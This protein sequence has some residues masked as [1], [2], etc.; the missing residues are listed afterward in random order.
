VLTSGV[1]FTAADFDL[2][3]RLGDDVGDG[4]AAANADALW[5]KTRR[6]I[7][8]LGAGLFGDGLYSAALWPDDDGG[9]R[10]PFLWARL[11]R[12]GSERFATHIG[13]F[14]S[15]GLC[16]LAI[17][18][19]KDP[20][21]AGESAESLAQVLDFYRAEALGLIDPPARPDLRVWTDTRNVIPAG[22]LGAVH[23]ADFMAANSDAGHPWPKV[24][25][26]LSAENVVDFGDDWLAEYHPRAVPLVPIYDAM[27]RSFTG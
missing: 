3:Q 2:L 13:V 16:N 18:L 4:D 20:L 6:L 8:Q 27:L 15:P 10:G 5:H 14:L 9:E 25:Y 11:K 24:G 12:A 21:D 19:E 7:A 26:L 23:F 1:G 17:D 22:D